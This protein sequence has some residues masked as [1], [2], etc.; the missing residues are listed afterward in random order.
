MGT[1]P[2]RVLIAE[3]LRAH[4]IRG[5][6]RLVPL[7]G[8]P[9]RF[10]P[11]LVVLWRPFKGPAEAARELTFARVRGAGDTLY[12][13][14]DEVSDRTE[15]ETLNGGGLWAPPEADA[16]LPPDTYYHHQLL[17]LEVVDE[18]GTSL[19]RLTAVLETGPHDVYEVTTP[20]KQRF[21]VPAVQAFVVR[22]ELDTNRLVIH[23]VPGLLPDSADNIADDRSD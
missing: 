11:G 1:A 23:L 15:A 5:E 21:L 13:T 17:G 9:R 12:A 6:V 3:R 19:G 8:S 18:G 7:G 2:E 10:Q 14:F 22:V 16:D 20:D 4:G